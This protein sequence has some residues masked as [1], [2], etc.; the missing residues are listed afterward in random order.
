MAYTPRGQAWVDGPAAGNAIDAEDLNRLEA[1][2]SDANTRLGSIESLGSLATDAEVA[3]AVSAHAAAANPHTVYLLSSAAPELIRDT[4]GTAL[5]AGANVTITPNDAGDTIAVAAAATDPEVVR[6]TMATALVAGANVTITP[7]D[8]ANTITI[9]SS[10]GGVTDPEVV[11]DT[12]AAA[13]VAGTNV[14]ITPN[15]AAD[16][17]TIA[18]AGSGDA[19]TPYGRV[20]LDDFAGA[21][22]DAKLTAALSAT[23]ADTYPRTITLRARQYNFATGNRIAFEGMRIEGPPGY[24]NPERNSQTKMPSRCALTMSTPWFLN[25]LNSDVFSVSFH[26]MSFTGGSNATVIGQNGSGTWYCLSMRD[27]FSSG[28]RTVVGTQATKVLMT[29]ASFTGDWEINNC[30]NGAF[31]MGG[32]DNVFWSDGMLLDSGTAFNTA[33]SANGQYHIWMDGME[34]SDIGPLYITAEGPW[35]G[36]RI[37]G[38]GFNSTSN[39]QGGPL[40]FRGLRLEGRNAGAPC[41]GSLIRNEGGIV[42]VR[43]SWLAYAMGSPATPG[44]SPADAGVVHHASGTLLVSGCTYDRATGVAET[45]PFVYTNSNADCIVTETLRAAKGGTWTGRPRVAKP[46]ANPENRLIDGTATLLS[47]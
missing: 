9:A 32:S 40:V 20:F 37:S 38:P 19:A 8:T 46:A 2:G 35:N 23:A 44:H 15:D 16:T 29:A 4:I 3:A 7:D 25:P 42:I 22:D 41:N 11:R 36:I 27:I 43:D 30:Y 26:Q 6:D 31:H 45:V 13:L 14:T 17:I 18:A 24:G 28:L 47:V 33:G 1:N 39:N 10:G 34:K 21:D 5:V 12:M